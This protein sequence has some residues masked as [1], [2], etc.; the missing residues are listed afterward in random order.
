MLPV[1]EI[2]SGKSLNY[3]T[4]FGHYFKWFKKGT[5]KDCWVLFLSRN[6]ANVDLSIGDFDGRHT[7]TIR[8]GEQ[9][10][11]QGR[12]RCKTT[13]AF[14]L[15]DRLELPLAMSKPVSGNHN[16]LYEIEVHAEEVFV[17]LKGAGIS[18][19]GLFVNGD[20]GFDSERFRSACTKRGVIPNLPYN[21]RKGD[22]EREELFDEK[23][24]REKYSVERTFAWM[25]SFLCVLNRFD[26]TTTSWKGFNFLVFIVIAIKNIEITS[27]FKNSFCS[28]SKHLNFNK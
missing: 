18:T 10:E 6:R 15:T 19:E 9:L 27:I 8:G 14:Y 13:N 25:E 28:I 16:D 1:D 17:T 5:W 2:F 23:L 21:E 11:Y 12:K 22:V 4:V 7:M 24:Y 26:T 20:A 3:K